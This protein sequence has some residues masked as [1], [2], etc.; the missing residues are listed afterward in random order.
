MEA[1]GL[2]EQSKAKRVS[3]W[4]CYIEAGCQLVFHAAPLGDELSSRDDLPPLYTA[5]P[6]GSPALH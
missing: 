6:S 4:S 3:P 1:L 5:S 2:S